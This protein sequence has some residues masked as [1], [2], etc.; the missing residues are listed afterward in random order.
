PELG[1]GP[2]LRLGRGRPVAAP[3]APFLCCLWLPLGLHL[4]HLW[5]QVLLH[6]MPGDA[7]GHQ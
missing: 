4:R 5:G 2:Q 6:T 1:R 3:P 7:P